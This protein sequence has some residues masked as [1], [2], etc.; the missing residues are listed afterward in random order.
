MDLLKKKKRAGAVGAGQA[1]PDPRPARAWYGRTGTPLSNPDRTARGLSS[2][3]DGACRRG[4]AGGL[5]FQAPTSLS[6]GLRRSLATRSM[7]EQFRRALLARGRACRGIGA[8]EVVEDFPG[9][10]W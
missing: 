4:G 7:V 2:S 9:E 8:R 1:S 6:R 10:L 3:R 5:G